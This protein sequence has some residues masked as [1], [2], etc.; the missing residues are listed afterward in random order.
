MVI[1]KRLTKVHVFF[2]IVSFLYFTLGCTRVNPSD[3]TTGVD[4][5]INPTAIYIVPVTSEPDPLSGARWKLVAFESEESTTSIPEQ[6]LFY[7]EFQK[8]ELSLHG[9]CNS[10]GGHYVLQNDNITITFTERTEMDCSHLGPNVNEIEEVF[11]IAMLTFDSY[12]LEGE[13]LRIRYI[14]G[15]LLLRRVQDLLFGINT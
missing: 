5:R 3:S 13:Q 2:T 15:E 6:S 4:T 14:D 8:G 12:T 10:V 11:S 9:G 1:V 7:V